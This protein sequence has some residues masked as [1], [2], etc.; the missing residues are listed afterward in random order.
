MTNTALDQGL[1]ILANWKCNSRKELEQN[2]RLPSSW[3]KSLTLGFKHR[4]CHILFKIFSFYNCLQLTINGNC[5]QQQ[6][7]W[8]DGFLFLGS[9]FLFPIETIGENSRHK[10]ETLCTCISTNIR[11]S[12]FNELWI[13]Y[14]I[15]W[16][17]WN[18]KWTMEFQICWCIRYLCDVELLN[19]KCVR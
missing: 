4:S 15:M 5:K 9:C 7:L 19:R 10:S 2:R 1:W 16:S 3:D 6:N 17:I 8:L 12:I 11:L 13:M 14:Y 18:Y